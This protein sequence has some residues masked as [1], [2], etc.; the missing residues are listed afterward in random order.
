MQPV[1]TAGYGFALNAHALQLHESAITSETTARLC[2]VAAVAG[3]VASEVHYQVGSSVK[4]PLDVL[5]GRKS[6]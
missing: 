5:V 6:S 1:A 3:S 2:M 4:I